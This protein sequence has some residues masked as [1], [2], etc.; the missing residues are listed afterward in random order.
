MFPLVPSLLAVAFVWAALA[1]A[2][3]PPAWRS[4][5]LGYRLPD[6]L[7]TPALV[8]V[9]VVEVVAAFLLAAGGAATKAGAALA[10][11]LLA[12]FSLAVLRARR[13][14]GDRLPCGCFGGTGSRDYRLMLVRNAFL[15]AVAA[16]V[17][18]VPRLARY[19]LEVPSSGEVVPAL[20]VAGAAAAITWL[21]L[22]VTRGFGR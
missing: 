16:A 2:S 19:E 11:A 13:L 20:L 9:P 12:A 7:V 22:S 8:G 18:L 14:E 21:A 4:A 10:V 1:K 6:Q 3:R 17:L 5:L 15:G